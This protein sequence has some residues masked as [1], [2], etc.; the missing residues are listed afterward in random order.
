MTSCCPDNSH[1]SQ[2]PYDGYHWHCKGVEDKV[3]DMSVY[4]TG[5]GHRCIIWC[6]DIYGFTVYCSVDSMTYCVSPD[7]GRQDKTVV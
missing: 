1:D 5:A 2:T 7:L 4:R 3:G 6:Y